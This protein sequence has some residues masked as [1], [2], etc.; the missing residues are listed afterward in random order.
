[1]VGGLGGLTKALEAYFS[2]LGSEFARDWWTSINIEGYAKT[3]RFGDLIKQHDP[4]LIILTL[5]ANDFYV[6]NPKSLAPFVRAISK[7]T[8]GRECWWL[9]PVP[10]TKAK[11]TGIVEVIAANAAPCKVFDGSQL[12]LARASDG[13][14]PSN[15]GGRQWASAF[16]EVYNRER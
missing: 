5:G 7:K 2:P 14:H 16:L 4:D 15:E 13:V 10:W 1:M 11:E 6:P 12:K 9:T 8:E 3:K